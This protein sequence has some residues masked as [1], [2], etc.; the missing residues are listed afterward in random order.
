MPALF[1]IILITTVCLICCI[2][3]CRRNSSYS[4]EP[5]TMTPLV[6]PTTYASAATTITATAA[7]SS[8][9]VNSATAI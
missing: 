7:I 4:N 5:H 9:P 6:S 1:G 3:Q 8:E 2:R